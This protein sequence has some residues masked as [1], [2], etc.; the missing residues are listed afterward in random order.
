MSNE[1]AIVLGQLMMKCFGSA[2]LMREIIEL[3]CFGH[4]WYGVT[5]DFDQYVRI[6]REVDRVWRDRREWIRRS[7]LSTAG[8]GCFSSDST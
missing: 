1:L 6:Q 5:F 8:M 4:D 7:I 2:T 3:I